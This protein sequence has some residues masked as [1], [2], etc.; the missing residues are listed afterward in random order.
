MTGG[1]YGSP[2]ID[3]CRARWTLPFVCFAERTAK[4]DQPPK[5]RPAK[6]EVDDV[7]R[8]AHPLNASDDRGQEIDGNHKNDKNT[9]L[10]Q[11][12]GSPMARSRRSNGRAKFIV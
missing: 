11:F 9:L 3:Q 1:A 6:E 2:P 4:G 12:Q 8:G 7:N 10:E 5:H